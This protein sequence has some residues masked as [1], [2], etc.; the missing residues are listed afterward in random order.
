MS[1]LL[2][3]TWKK[4]EW[5]TNSSPRLFPVELII[6]DLIWEIIWLNNE[7]YN[8]KNWTLDV[9]KLPKRIRLFLWKSRKNSNTTYS[10][11]L[12]QLFEFLSVSELE[13]FDKYLDWRYPEF[14]TKE[15]FF[16]MFIRSFEV[17]EVL[18]ANLYALWNYILKID[19]EEYYTL[20]SKEWEDFDNYADE[21]RKKYC[22]K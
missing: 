14:M 12:R 7:K 13:E 21:L 9:S 1:N 16:E 8:W 6:K 22:S 15:V 10:Y 4:P 20:I 19:P 3:E 5:D 18:Q 2:S 11:S 17:G